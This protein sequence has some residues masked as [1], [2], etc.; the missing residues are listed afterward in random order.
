[1]PKMSVG[2]H[3]GGTQEVQ[4]IRLCEEDVLWIIII[5]IIIRIRGYR[6]NSHFLNDAVK[7]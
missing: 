2:L 7:K 3:E 6:V 5:I 1:M 4:I